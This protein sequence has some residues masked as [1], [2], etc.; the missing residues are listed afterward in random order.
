MSE[1]GAFISP[2]FDKLV[3]V[4]G[5]ERPITPGKTKEKFI[6]NWGKFMLWFGISVVVLFVIYIALQE[7]YK[8]YYEKYLFKNPDDLFNI[9]TFIYNARMG[10]LKDDEIR[11]KLSASGWKGEQLSFA[12]NKISGR[13][14]GMFEIPIFKSMEQKRLQQELERRRGSPIDTRFIKRP[15]L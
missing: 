8:R 2:S 1:L 4:S 6:F 10:G 7:W 15:S 9:L 3:V 14:T 5:D 13:R 12:F 11:R